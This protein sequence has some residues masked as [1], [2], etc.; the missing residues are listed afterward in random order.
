[1]TGSRGLFDSLPDHAKENVGK[2]YKI[3][4]QNQAHP[5][6]KKKTDR[7]NIKQQVQKPQN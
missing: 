6:F 4:L 1:V 3:F 2:Q 5:Y 7:I